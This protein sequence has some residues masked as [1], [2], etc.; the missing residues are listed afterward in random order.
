M[1]SSGHFFSHA[2]EVGV[3]DK[4]MI[5]NMYDKGRIINFGHRTLINTEYVSVLVRNMPIHNKACYQRWKE[6]LN[7]LVEVVNQRIS[8]VQRVLDKQSER[9]RLQPLITDIQKLIDSLQ[10][11]GKRVLN[12]EAPHHISRLLMTWESNALY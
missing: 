6:N 2:G 7:L 5:E 4:E 12:E 3:L 10:A 1:I 11:P 9:E 8:D